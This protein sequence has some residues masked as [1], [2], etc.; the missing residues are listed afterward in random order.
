MAQRVVPQRPRLVAER[1]AADA[2]RDGLERAE[3]RGEQPALRQLE[4]VEL[5]GHVDPIDLVHEAVPAEE[6]AVGEAGGVH[7]ALAHG[8]WGGGRLGDDVVRS[9]GAADVDLHVRELRDVH[10]DGIVQPQQAALH[11]Q[12]GG[13]G[14]EDLGLSAQQSASQQQRGSV[15]ECCAPASSSGTCCPR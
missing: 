5:V 12:Q 10:L 14:G 8:G 13:H 7:E 15:A 9:D 6:P 4:D 3:G 2:R 1:E 11:G